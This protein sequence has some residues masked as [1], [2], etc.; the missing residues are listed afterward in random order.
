M[1]RVTQAHIDA[2]TNDILEAARRM[3]VRKGVEAATMQEI[4]AEAGLSAGAIYR[5][6][7]SKEHLL[8][9][10]CGDWIEHDRAL[11][12]RGAAEAG[13]PLAGL[14]NVGR[15][16]WD[17]MKTE[18]ARADT[19]LTLETMLA[20]VRQPEE[21]APERRQAWNAVIDLIERFLRPAQAAGEIDPQLDARAFATMALALGL[22]TRLLALE[23]GDDM[24]TDA[25]FAVLT[26]MLDAFTPAPAGGTTA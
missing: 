25:V 7:T 23:L 8:R 19:I 12:E 11:F 14:L 6:Y 4:A 13:S 2:R 26:R 17:E 1:T 20:A 16:V 9:A 10:V 3:F 22:G 18:E 15:A 24:D 21:L 5:Y